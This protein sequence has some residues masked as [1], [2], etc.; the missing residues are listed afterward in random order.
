MTAVAEREDG[1]LLAVAPDAMGSQ[2]NPPAV[3]VL[4]GRTWPTTVQ[5]AL[6]R[7]TWE[8]ADA[9]IE[10]DAD[11]LLR[12]AGNGDERTKTRSH[13]M[14][15]KRSGAPEDLPF[16]VKSFQPSIKA[17]DTSGAGTATIKIASFGEVDKDGDVTQPGFFGTQHVQFVPTHN[18]DHVWLGKGRVYE[19]SDGAYCDVK[20]N[21]DIQAARDWYSAIKF[22]YENPPSLAQYSYGYNVLPGGSK[23]GQHQGRQVRILQPRDDGSPGV[24][25][26]EVGSVMQGAGT[27][28]RT[29]SVKGRS[30]RIN[31]ASGATTSTVARAVKGAI[32]SHET[33]TASRPWDNAKTVKALPEDSLPSELRTVFA[34][35]DPDGDNES[36]T[37][38]KMAHHHGLGGPANLRACLIGIAELNQGTTDIPDA[39]RKGVY[40]HLAAHIRDADREPPELRVKGSGPGKQ[41][42]QLLE[43]LATLSGLIDGVY[44]G[45][46]RQE[47]GRGLSRVKSELLG[48]IGDDL[49]RLKALLSQPAEPEVVQPSDDELASLA[50]ASLARINGF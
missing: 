3:I 47:K 2:D 30:M 4:D 32:P 49:T 48:W 1:A 44:S 37:S 35:V 12:E 33:K 14:S 43:G 9:E 34:W 41:Y 28:T 16:A 15:T 19:K 6:A 24:E 11:P 46:A 5:S 36:L 27:D 26:F 17:V 22:D 10:F 7:G 21:M 25:V 8:P 38:Y 31:R 23:S 29:V 13:S 20:F 50:A 40:D 42:D 45:A 39:D 18:W